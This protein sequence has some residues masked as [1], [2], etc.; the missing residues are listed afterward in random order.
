MF[1]TRLAKRPSFIQL[2]HSQYTSSCEL[3]KVNISSL[4]DIAFQCI[5]GVTSADKYKASSLVEPSEHGSLTE[6]VL[7]QTEASLCGIC[8]GRSGISIQGDQ[9]SSGML[10]SVQWQFRIDVSGQPIGPISKAPRPLTVEDG[11]DRLSRNVAKKLP[12]LAA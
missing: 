1:I 6:E 12:L 10:H 8:V 5:E 3:R 2:Q 7:V 9:R 11:T 4:Q